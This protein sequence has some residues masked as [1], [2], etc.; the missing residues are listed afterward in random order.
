MIDTVSAGGGNAA[1]KVGV[2]AAKALPCLGL[3]AL[4]WPVVLVVGE[5][6]LPVVPV[7]LVG[8]LVPPVE[9]WVPPVVLVGEVL[10]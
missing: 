10:R 3:P 9:V 7:P 4:L 6:P 1:S 2:L 5:A 8:V